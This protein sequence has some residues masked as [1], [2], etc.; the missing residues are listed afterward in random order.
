[1]PL[2][3]QLNNNVAS[4][5]VL[6]PVESFILAIELYVDHIWYQNIFNVY[7]TNFIHASTYP[8][9]WWWCDDKNA[10]SMFRL[11]QNVLNLLKLNCHLS[12]TLF[13]LVACIL[14]K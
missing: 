2:I 5:G 7:C 4:W 9:L 8:L 11:L 10:C 14:Q 12:M 13:S 3:G 1:M 6:V